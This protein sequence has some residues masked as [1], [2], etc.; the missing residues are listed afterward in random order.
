MNTETA[1]MFLS[2]SPVSGPQVETSGVLDFF[3]W[4]LKVPKVSVLQDRE[5]GLAL[6]NLAGKTNRVN[7]AVLYGY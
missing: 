2:T 3:K 1:G 5:T 4:Q 6:F 7:V